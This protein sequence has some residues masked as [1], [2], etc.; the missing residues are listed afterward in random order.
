M[1]DAHLDR[2]QV[3]R[4]DVISLDGISTFDGLESGA[5]IARSNY[6]HGDP[7]RARRVKRA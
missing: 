5:H 3:T 6:D 7:V 2:Y 1:T 4:G